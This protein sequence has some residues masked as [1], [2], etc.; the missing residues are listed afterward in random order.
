[1]LRKALFLFAALA[2]CSALAVD[3]APNQVGTD[4]QHLEWA[5]KFIRFP[6]PDVTSTGSTQMRVR[7]PC[8]S[9]ERTF[10]RVPF[11]SWQLRPC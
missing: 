5:R 11:G 10:D 2:S 8:R 3:R 4:L 7:E 6:N 9:G 1:M